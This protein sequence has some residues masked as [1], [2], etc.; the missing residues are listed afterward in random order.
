MFIIQSGHLPQS[1]I[2]F[3]LLHQLLNQLICIDAVI[4]SAVVY[5]VRSGV[6]RVVVCF[7]RMGL[8]GIGKGRWRWGKVNQ[9]WGN[10]WGGRGFGYV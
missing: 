2:P 5:V 7:A 6:V 8:T 1:G 4:V 9:R 3:G 10:G